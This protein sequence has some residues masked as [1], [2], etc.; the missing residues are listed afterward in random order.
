MTDI[1]PEMREI[2][3]EGHRIA[4]RNESVR[5]DDRLVDLTVVRKTPN[6]GKRPPSHARLM[7]EDRNNAQ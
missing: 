1:T 6:P 5:Y 3:A 7:Q 2:A 4:K